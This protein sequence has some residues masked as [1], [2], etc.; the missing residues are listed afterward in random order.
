MVDDLADDL[1]HDLAHDLADDE[2]SSGRP[3][4]RVRGVVLDTPDPV[5]L[6]AFYARL[7]GWPYRSE[8]P[9]WVVLLDPGGGAGLSFQ[10]EDHY[11]APVWP[12]GPDDPA[13]MVHL[14]VEADDL[15]AAVGW[16]ERCGA[17]VARYQP[18][19]HVRVCL[20]PDGHPFCLY[21]EEEA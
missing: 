7:L 1:A 13:M 19:E 16:A 15:M 4:L 17:R 18:Q 9:G 10:R 11:R 8:D 2:A 21:V 3:A 6:A 12:A 14:D 5:A 20:D